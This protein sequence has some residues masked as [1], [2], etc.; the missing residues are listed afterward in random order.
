MWPAKPKDPSLLVVLS[1]HLIWLPEEDRS[2][3]TGRAIEVPIHSL[4]GSQASLE[5]ALVVLAEQLRPMT[6]A[7]SRQKLN[8]LLSDRWMVCDTV[9]WSDA[10]MGG[11]GHRYLR[12]SLQRI[13]Y[14]IEPEAMF[15]VEDRIPGRPCW[16]A[17]LPGYLRNVLAHF[18]DQ[19]KRS[20]NTCSPV[21]PAV[22]NYL[23]QNQRTDGPVGILDGAWLR[24]Y[25]VRRR[26]CEPISCSLPVD[27][28]ESSVLLAW[29]RTQLAHAGIE[30][31]E[32]FQIVCLKSDL[33]EQALQLPV[34]NLDGQRS[35]AI[36]ENHRFTWLRKIVDEEHLLAFR[37]PTAISNPYLEWSAV[38][39][40]VALLGA[41]GWGGSQVEAA[42]ALR[43]ELDHA[44]QVVQEPQDLAQPAK[45]L[46]PSA[47][48]VLLNFPFEESLRSLLPQDG[49]TVYLLGVE[50]DNETAPSSVRVTGQTRTLDDV[51]AYLNSLAADS[52]VKH[53]ELLRHE[54]IQDNPTLPLRFELEVIW[55]S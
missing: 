33:D 50:F 53:V 47:A 5:G 41:I 29:Q 34:L 55:Q 31:P 13:G 6:D 45:E 12:E 51:A 37:S 26:G 17:C 10:L 43:S 54:R 38:I 42:I 16:G 39:L 11:D 7:Y 46:L 14:R 35:P 49:M 25:Q 2:T 27:S 30:H 44:L 40:V 52:R 32:R 21:G 20:L 36:A 1:D 23:I 8:V 22:C 28:G 24:I 48:K 9:P 4:G 18:A 3:G 15:Q 19:I